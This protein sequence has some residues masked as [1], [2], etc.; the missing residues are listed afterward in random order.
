M[1]SR[2]FRD[3]FHDVLDMIDRVRNTSV[4][5]N[6]FIIEVDLSVSVHGN[7]LQ[8]SVTFDGVIDVRFCFLAQ[9]DNFSIAS[10]FVVEHAVIIPSVFVVTDQKTFRV[11]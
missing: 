8:Q 4:L 1:C 10:T 5:G 2:T 6:R 11:S 7:I 3:R 9:V